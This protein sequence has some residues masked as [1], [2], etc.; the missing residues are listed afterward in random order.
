[1]RSFVKY[2]IIYF[3][4]LLFVL[5]CGGQNLFSKKNRSKL[6]IVDYQRYLNK[7]F[8][9]RRRKSTKYIIVHT[10]EAGKVSTLRTLSEGKRV[11]P[12]R[13]TRGGHANYTIL[14]NGRIYKILD[15]KYRADHTGLSMWNGLKDLSSHS[16]GIELVGYHYGKI[17]V[18]QYRSLTPLLKELQRIYNIPDKNILT[19]S[20]VSFGRPNTWFRNNHRG[21]KRCALNFNR[22]RAGLVGRWTYDPDVAARRLTSDYQIKKVF[23]SAYN[24]NMV[25]TSPEKTEKILEMVKIEEAVKQELVTSS[26]I[27]SADNTAWNIAGEDYNDS[28]TIYILPNGEKVRGNYAGSEI[29][30]SNIPTGTKVILNQPEIIENSDDPVKIISGDL[31]AWSYAGKGYKKRST[32][33]IFPDGRIKDGT[34][35]KDW[36]S[37][38]LGVRMIIGYIGPFP[39]GSEK[40]KTAWGIAGKQYN[41]KETVYV[42]PGIGIVTGDKMGS[43]NDLPKYSKLFL[44][45]RKNGMES[46]PYTGQR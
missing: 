37:L 17:T 9:K 24:K 42:I 13:R 6:N 26:N 46:K 41:K 31:T 21:R 35:I 23:Y 1:M 11:G 40:G 12:R 14:R 10:S 20:Q 45:R 28:K 7:K 8:K 39:L 22:S 19:H 43:F 33:Y 32:F 25:K 2:K 44:K 15:H 4:L 36:D 18:E 5:S 16:I 3:L 34:R 38:P 27:I 29:G 30:W